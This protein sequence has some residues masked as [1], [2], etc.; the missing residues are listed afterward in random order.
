MN[1]L[2][3]VKPVSAP[4]SLH[5]SCALHCCHTQVFYDA[6]KVVTALQQT[7]EA[8]VKRYKEQELP[9]DPSLI[10]KPLVPTLRLMKLHMLR[11]LQVRMLGV[12][13]FG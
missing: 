13:W 8:V 5:Q 2:L 7:S 10:R 1:A 9:W 12:P 3:A 11:T 4:A 6:S